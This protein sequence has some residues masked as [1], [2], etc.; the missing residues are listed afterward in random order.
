MAAGRIKGV[1]TGLKLLASDCFFIGLRAKAR[2]KYTLALDWLGE[3]LRL[4]PVDGTVGN[5]AV[6]AALVDL[7]QEVSF[8]QTSFFC[9]IS[10]M[11]LSPNV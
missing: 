5:S 10:R 6:K 9:V 4:A 3:A 2:G 1:D 11:T 8:D 7:C